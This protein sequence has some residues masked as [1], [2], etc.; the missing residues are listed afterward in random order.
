MDQRDINL[1]S[2]R[3]YRV[4]IGLW[5]LAS[6]DKGLNGE[7]P[8]IE[9]IAFRLRME[10][11][12]IIKALKELDEFLI[13]D[14]IEMISEGCQSDDTETETETEEEIKTEKEPKS[15]FVL[16]DWINQELWDGFMAERKRQ[17]ASNSEAAIKSLVTKLSKFREEGLDP[18]ESVANSLEN[19]WKGV[20]PTKQKAGGNGK[21]NLSEALQNDMQR[22]NEREMGDSSIRTLE[23]DLSGQVG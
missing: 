1:L 4:L 6:E 15:V 23:S 18:N 8:E 21:F 22:I 12:K 13:H 9:D 11:D 3:S 7:L 10:K 17:K 5:L 20:F 14:D 16:P 2:D 19:S